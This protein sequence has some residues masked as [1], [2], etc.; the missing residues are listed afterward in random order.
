MD[1]YNHINRK[2]NYSLNELRILQRNNNRLYK[3]FEDMNMYIKVIVDN[4][5]GNP[6]LIKLTITVNNTLFELFKKS[7]IENRTMYAIIDK[8]IFPQILEKS[9]YDRTIP[10][11]ILIQVSE[12]TIVLPEETSE[13][14]NVNIEYIPSLLSELGKLNILHDGLYI[15]ILYDKSANYKSGDIDI[16]SIIFGNKIRSILLPNKSTSIYP[17]KIIFKHPSQGDI[18]SIGTYLEYINT[19]GRD[20]KIKINN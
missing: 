1:S 16:C 12:L 15:N 7:I 9:G 17:D 19:Q 5:I 4:F 20:V 13:L 18:D 2:I 3:L 11:N 14:L 6:M 8:V 10:N